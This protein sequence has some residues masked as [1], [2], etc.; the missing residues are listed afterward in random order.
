MNF[1]Y[2]KE[3]AK[4]KLSGNWGMII[5]GTIIYLIISG[6]MFSVNE[7]REFAN[8]VHM[9]TR[10]GNIFQLIL[11]GP[12]TL[13]YFF[14][15][16]GISQNNGEYGDLFRGFKRFGDTFV[17]HLLTSIIIIIGFILLI[18]P[19][20]IW[21][22]G[23]SMGYLIMKD[24]PDVSG[25]EA[26]RMSKS[27]MNGNKSE[28]FSFCLS[29]IGWFLLGIITLGF[30]FLYLTPYFT[31]AKIEFYEALKAQSIGDHNF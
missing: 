30:G 22:L 3:S 31:A 5:I 12:A 13:G 28:Y 11:M 20:I 16:I 1:A 21:A 8:G 18:V 15:L 29:F 24:N 2:F 4:E 19:G 9:E 23:Y 27:L 7:T 26:M 10:S 6:Q 17:Y 14:F 25:M